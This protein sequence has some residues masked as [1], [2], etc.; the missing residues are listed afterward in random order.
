MPRRPR[1]R[2]CASCGENHHARPTVHRGFADRCGRGVRADRPGT[3]ERTPLTRPEAL[4][5]IAR[6]PLRR[7]PPM[8]LE[9]TTSPLPRVC[10]TTELR[11][12]DQN[13]ARD[14]A[15]TE[16]IRL[17][18]PRPSDHGQLRQRPRSRGHLRSPKKNRP[19][20]DGSRS[21]ATPLPWARGELPDSR[22]LG[23]GR[24]HGSRGFDRSR[25]HA[26]RMGPRMQTLALQGGTERAL[27]AHR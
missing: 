2:E 8:G 19:G 13:V 10:S 15:P 21:V 9:P 24:A 16:P 14:R 26:G 17:R 18:R 25:R 3:R 1:L 4:I 5:A 6:S 12:H 27:P 7:E 20:R 23:E 22:E 11:W